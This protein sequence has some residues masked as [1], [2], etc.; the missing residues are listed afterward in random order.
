MNSVYHVKNLLKSYK[1]TDFLLQTFS[2]YNGNYGVRVSPRLFVI[3][4]PE[5]YWFYT[6]PVIHF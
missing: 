3:I 1:I 6:G 4:F 5:M 2:I